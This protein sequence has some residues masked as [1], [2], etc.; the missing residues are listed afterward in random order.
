MKLHLI[1]I[2]KL[3]SLIAVSILT[4]FPIF[5][6]ACDRTVLTAYMSASDEM[7]ALDRSVHTF[8][9]S[10]SSKQGMDMLILTYNAPDYIAEYRQ[11][12]NTLTD[13]QPRITDSLNQFY[14]CS[15]LKQTEVD[16]RFGQTFEQ[17]DKLLNH[18][19]MHATSFAENKFS[20]E[21]KAAHNQ[22]I[23]FFG[24]SESGV[25]EPLQLTQN[26]YKNIAQNYAK[27]A[28]IFE[29]WAL[30]E[31]RGTERFMSVTGLNILNYSPEAQLQLH[32]DRGLS[33][34]SFLLFGGPADGEEYPQ[35]IHHL[36]R[37]LSGYTGDGNL[38][39]VDQIPNRSRLAI[40]I[41]I[42]EANKQELLELLS[43]YETAANQFT[44]RSAQRYNIQDWKQT[45]REPTNMEELL[46]F[47]AIQNY[48]QI[49]K[50]ADIIDELVD[51]KLAKDWQTMVEAIQ[52]K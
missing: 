27:Q 2:Q 4:F 44:T 38:P 5:S 46:Q 24:D 23:S 7:Q 28:T 17:H 33:K 51:P 50:Q 20:S 35:S 29:L 52:T 12:L 32:L 39:T 36:A 49:R 41:E 11:R 45:D 34:E 9:K 42:S 40:I 14:L 30:K 13:N 18:L 37:E 1:K 6:E 3:C 25:M 10:L 8:L 21:I 19:Q 31:A 22:A 26:I 15:G 48:Q 43:Q 47:W 16:T